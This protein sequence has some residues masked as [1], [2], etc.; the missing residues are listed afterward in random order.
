MSTR[1]I[2]Y[3]S[4]L[5]VAAA[6]GL[7]SGRAQ[8]QPQV[9]PVTVL[10]GPAPAGVYLGPVTP[11]NPPMFPAPQ[12]A[13]PL[14]DPYVGIYGESWTWQLLPDG[15]LYKA[16]LAGG[17]ESRFASEFVH[18]KNLG[19]LWDIAL[20]GHVGLIRSGTPDAIVPEGWQVDLEGAAFP[21]L[22]LDDNRGLVAT[23]FR[24]G[25]PLTTRQGPWE[26]KFGG[27]HLSSHFGDQFL[28]EHP[29]VDRIHYSR[30]GLVVGGG[31][32]PTPDWRLYAEAGWAFAV[33][34]GAKPWEFQFGGEY[35]P[36]RPTG[37]QGAPFLAVNGH[38]RQENNFGGN[39]IAEAGW[40][41]RG[42]S[43]HLF[44]TGLYYFNGMSDETEFFTTSEQ[45]LGVGLWYDY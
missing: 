15:L 14:V 37:C 10:G 32:R 5:L 29:D 44:R 35:S 18:D 36:A 31:F 13:Q 12:P 27:Y 24:F 7:C 8:A 45:L 11:Q 22:T 38:L 41:W 21:R 43:G 42:Q 3:L 2:N 39:L 9:M 30:T 4:A 19:P 33:W 28:T 26:W 17:R 34:G 20:G 25:V 40:Q 1:S 16:Y 23:D 6:I